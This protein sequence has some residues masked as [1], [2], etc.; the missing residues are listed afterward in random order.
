MSKAALSRQKRSTTESDTSALLPAPHAIAGMPDIAGDALPATAATTAATATAGHTLDAIA[1]QRCGPV[2]CDCAD[3]ER[4]ASEE[5]YESG[6]DQEHASVSHAGHMAGAVQR[7]PDDTLPPVDPSAGTTAL[8]GS[9]GDAT[10]LNAGNTGSTTIHPPTLNMADYSAPTLA[11]VASLF[12]DEVGFVDFRFSV[13]TSGDPITSARLDVVQPMT[14]PRWVEYDKQCQPVKRAWDSF[15]TALRNHENGHVTRDNQEFAGQH[16]RYIGQP[17]SETQTVSDKLR[18]DVQAVQ[19][20]YDTATDH[21]RNQNPPTILDTTITC[22]PS[23]ASADLGASDLGE[24]VA[25]SGDATGMAD[26]SQTMQAARA[27]GG[28]SMHAADEIATSVQA[29]MGSSNGQPLDDPTRSFMES[30]FSHNFGHVRVHTD[31]EAARSAASARAS[32]YTIGSDIVFA[33]GQYQPNTD[34]GRHLLAHELTH[35]VQQSEGPVSGTALGNGLTISDPSDSYE[36]AAEATAATVTSGQAITPTTHTAIPGQAQRQMQRWTMPI[37]TLKSN[38]ELL[39]DGSNG[40]LQAI[41]EITD[42]SGATDD[43]RF[44]MIRT[45]LNQSWVGPRD[46]YALEAIWLSFGDRVTAMA[47]THM[48][49]WRQSA[50]RGAELKEKV[51]QVSAL[52]TKFPDDVKKIVTN[53]LFLN[54]QLTMTELQE[55]GIPADENAPMPDANDAQ[56]RQIQGLQRAAAAV[57]KLQKAQEDARQIYVGFDVISF[58]QV[59]SMVGAKFDPLHRPDFKE[60]TSDLLMPCN[61]SGPITPYDQV[62]EKYDSATD[63]IT[64]WQTLYPDIYAISREGQSDTTAAFAA[65]TPAQARQKLG[66]GMRALIHDI[67]G[68]QIKLDGGDLNPLDLTP[69]HDQLLHNR[70]LGGAQAPSGTNWADPVAEWTA[71]ELVKD[72]QFA[73]ALT[74][75]ALQTAAQAAFLIAPFT[76]GASIFVLMAGLAATGIQAYRSAENYE[77][78]ASAAKTSAIPGT[79]LLAPGQVDEAKMMA[80]SDA[81]ALALAALAVGMAVA[82]EAIGAIKGPAAPKS[83]EIPQGLTEEQFEAMSATV[84]REAGQISSD[85]RVQGSRAAGTARPDSDIDIAIRVPKEQFNELVEENF[86]KPNQGSAKERTMQRAIETGKIQA[87]EAGLRPLRKTLQSQLG[88]DVDISVVRIGGPFDN[89]TM[90]P[91]K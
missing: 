3:D 56:T 58:D 32:A 20:A 85:I 51:P 23:K 21:G 34:S 39:Q 18:A 1:I 44:A 13:N 50:D 2:P 6:N 90:I 19:D 37:V 86:G 57:A 12:K 59:S 72:H 45:L 74:R 80:D 15:F 81:I 38:A 36:Q 9:S 82:A 62:K 11:D 65:M 22:A 5:H 49:L 75:L 4:A 53:Y 79:E 64:S 43:Q 42:F 66:V 10:Q 31:G 69:I 29:V 89:G 8:G 52:V 54:R 27:D 16:A 14:M 91:L 26:T 78:L 60:R 68:A 77:A 55:L 84:R 88:M 7:A 87:G 28:D 63:A 83:L 76:G 33:A 17:Q 48:D 24:S 35:V 71:R 40:D 30:R 41:K 73:E 70:L 47:G 25:T 61:Y 46:E 67:E